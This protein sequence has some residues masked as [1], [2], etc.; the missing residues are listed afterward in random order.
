MK[1]QKRYKS[2]KRN[3]KELAIFNEPVKSR[4]NQ[5]QKASN[6]VLNF[7][8]ICKL[9]HKYQMDN[10]MIYELHSQFI[11]IRDMQKSHFKIEHL[12]KQ[13]FQSF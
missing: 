11:S 12:G 6:D 8:N 5:V 13:Y 4:S 7:E 10:K 9:G 2:L 1:K 3:K